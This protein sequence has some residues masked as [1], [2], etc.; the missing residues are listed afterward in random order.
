[1]IALFRKKA[2][3]PWVSAVVAAAGSSSRMEGID[4]QCAAIDHTPVVARS[5]QALMACGLIREIVLVCPHGRIPEYYDIIRDY[6]L[7]LVS[8]VV[9]GGDTR[10]ASVFAGVDACS[11]Q[12][13]YFAIHDG[14]R[15]LVTPEE[16]ETCIEAAIQH[17]AAALGVRPK[18][19]IKRAGKDGYIAA[20]LERNELVAIQTPQVFEAGLYR[21]AMALAVRENKDFSDDCQLIERLGKKVYIAPGQYENIK[22]TTPHDLAIAQAVLQLREEGAGY[23]LALD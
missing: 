4:K 22:I 21:Q 10:Q 6:S 1:V 2:S 17:G 15:P 9:G 19:T 18:D 23:P 11:E 16:I 20:T 13:R 7:D 14:A 8:V 3:P 12:A 5:I